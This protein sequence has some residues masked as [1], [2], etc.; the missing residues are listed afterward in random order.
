VRRLGSPVLDS[1]GR[2]DGQPSQ[3]YWQAVTQVLSN[4]SLFPVQFD[5]W[6]N[7]DLQQQLIGTYGLSIA[8]AV[9][10]QDE[11]YSSLVGAHEN[12]TLRSTW[13]CALTAVCTND[14]QPTDADVG[15]A[16]LV[17]AQLKNAIQKQRWDVLLPN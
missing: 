4:P 3:E 15:K 2:R 1:S 6:L 5:T 12:Q 17:V 13:R 8:Q 7:R 10:V 11:L 14:T 9:Y 16:R